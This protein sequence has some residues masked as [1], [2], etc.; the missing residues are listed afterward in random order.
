MSS[1]KSSRRSVIPP[2]IEA[3]M[4]PVVKAFV[5]LL[6]DRFETR[7]DDLESQIQKLTPQ[8]SSL[9]AECATSA[10]QTKATQARW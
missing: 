2:E 8:N 7:I 9:S 3:E 6:I 1:P 4:T 10:C 5:E